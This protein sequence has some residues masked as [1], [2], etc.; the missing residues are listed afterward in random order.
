LS[1][2]VSKEDIPG[3]NI[4]PGKNGAQAVANIGESGFF[5]YGLRSEATHDSLLAMESAVIP[6]NTP[7]NVEVVIEI[8]RGSFLKRGSTGQIDFLSPVPCP[9]N[10][11]SVRR[12]IGGDGDFL[13]AIVLGPRLSAGSRVQVN[14][15]G[16]VGLSEGVVYDDKLI[17]STKPIS[18]DDRRNVL[19]FLR[20]YARCKGLLNIIRGHAGP[21]HCEGW[22]D[23]SA[24]IARAIPVKQK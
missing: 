17:C 2:T 19:L 20:F 9:Y 7:P 6:P 23:A 10:Y 1:D 15:Y 14:A 11:G 21:S 12:Y 13:D 3:H 5:M 16:A 4:S 18:P 8:S 24:A 22:G